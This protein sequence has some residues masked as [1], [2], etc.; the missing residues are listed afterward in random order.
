MEATRT[1]SLDQVPDNLYSTKID[2]ETPVGP[3]LLNA[4]GTLKHEFN[5]FSYP[6]FDPPSIDDAVDNLPDEKL[7]EAFR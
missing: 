5:Q 3:I 6:H 7:S 2:E 4:S 1:S